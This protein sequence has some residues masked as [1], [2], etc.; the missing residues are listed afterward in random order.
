MIIVVSDPK[1]KKAYAKKVDNASFLMGKK[2]GD[3]IELGI[4]GLDGYKA[5]ITGGSDKQGFPMKGDVEGGAR[6]RVYVFTDKKA[7]QRTKVSRRGKLISDETT[8]INLKITKDGKT[9]LEEI[10]TGAGKIKK[11]TDA[12]I[13]EQ[14]IQNS[15]VSAG[16]AEEAKNI[17]GKVKH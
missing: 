11:L 5:K 8:Q 16:S 13:K 2:V 17:K 10:F 7:G 6:R 9:A 14:M 3:E 1:S 4:I 12:E 15:L